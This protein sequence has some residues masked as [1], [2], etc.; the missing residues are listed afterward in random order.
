MNSISKSLPS[1][2]RPY[3]HIHRGMPQ[4]LF[5]L[6]LFWNHH[7]FSRG[8]RSGNCPLALAGVSDPPSLQQAI[9]SLLALPAA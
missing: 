3:L 8:K 4:W 1:W 7:V 2:L 6:Q 5:L 9:D